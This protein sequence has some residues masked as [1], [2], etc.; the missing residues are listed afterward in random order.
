MERSAKYFRAGTSY[1]KGAILV[2]INKEVATAQ[3]LSQKSD[4][5]NLLVS[6]LPDIRLDY[7]DHTH[8]KWL[9]YISKIDVGG[10]QVPPL[11]KVTHETEKLFLTSKKVFS[12]FYN[13]KSQEINLSKYEIH[14]PFDGTLSEALIR[15][16]TLVRG[17]QRLGTYI[18]TTEFEIKVSLTSQFFPFVK[19]GQRIRAKKSGV[20]SDN[21]YY[22]G[23]IKR[24][25]KR[26]DP[27]TQTF[28]IFVSLLGKDLL[29]GMY[30]DIHISG[31]PQTESFEID[32]SL[33]TDDHFVYTVEDG[34]LQKKA[35]IPVIFNQ[36]LLVFKGLPDSTQLV[37]S[38]LTKG[39]YEGM[40]VRTVENKSL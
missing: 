10:T 23:V 9:Q 37:I 1:K 13:L 39:Y 36:G 26:M 22:S 6:L 14:A 33:I 15:E 29:D 20:Q 35:I 18:S 11:P 40:A 28:E 24:I 16:G 17:G 21:T 34:K 38:P 8:T 12:T 4:F 7:E 5:Q 3:F 19:E 31:T 2:K 25:N 27:T 32:R 30:M